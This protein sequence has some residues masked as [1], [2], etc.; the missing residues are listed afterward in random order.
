MGG[1]IYYDRALSAGIGLP[2]GLVN[3]IQYKKADGTF[4]GDGSLQWDAAAKLFRVLDSTGEIIL[5]AD[6]TNFFQ[7]IG[8]SLKAWVKVDGTALTIRLGGGEIRIDKNILFTAFAYAGATDGALWYDS[9]QKAIGFY[10]KLKSFAE[11]VLYTQTNSVSINNSAAETTLLGTGIG[12]LGIPANMLTVGKMIRI[13]MWGSIA[14]TG[15]PTLQTKIKIGGTTVL[16]STAWTMTSITGTQIWKIEAIG[17]CRS[18]GAGGTVQWIGN[19][20]CNRTT[21]LIH[22]ISMAG[23]VVTTDTTAA[24]T[25]DATVQWGTAAAANA[26]VCNSVKI[27]ILN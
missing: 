24:N 5:Q 11:S 10:N 6:G 21:A 2:G 4:G 14:N 7:Q 25:I 12:T 20:M 1:G 23:S 13:E 8:D 27:E 19:F 3:N 9:T 15:T 26:I 22:S 16:D 18:V 17:T